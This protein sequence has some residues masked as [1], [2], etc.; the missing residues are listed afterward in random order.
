MNFWLLVIVTVVNGLPDES[1]VLG[2]PSKELCEEARVVIS[3]RAV[4]QGVAVWT[5][6][7]EMEGRKIPPPPKP[8]VNEDGP[9][10]DGNRRGTRS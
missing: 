1:K 4:A 2:G 7:I 6:C 9:S 3:K 5:K 8:D 10:P